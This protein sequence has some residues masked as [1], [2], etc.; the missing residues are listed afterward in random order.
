MNAMK[1]EIGK[2][3]KNISDGSIATVTNIV[4]HYV[5]NEI[6]GLV[7]YTTPMPYSFPKPIGAVDHLREFAD[8]MDSFCE[9]HEAI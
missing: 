5:D 9:R 4:L 2:Q 1:I 3:Y 7:E 8:E 6:R